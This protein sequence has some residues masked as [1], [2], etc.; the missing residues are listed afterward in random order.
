MNLI[1]VS[2][3]QKNE[4]EI[5][6]TPIYKSYQKLNK[7][8]AIDHKILFTSN[9]N[10][11]SKS[12][13]KSIKIIENNI[14]NNLYK[15]EDTYII[16]VH[17]D[18]YI[19]DIFLKEKLQ[20]AFNNFDIVGVAGSTI[21][22]LNSERVGW[23][24]SSKEYLSGSVEHLVNNKIENSPTYWTYFGIT[25]KRVIVIDGLFIAVKYTS[26][27]DKNYL[28]FDEQFTFDLYDID[29]CLNA[30]KHNL[31]IGTYNIHLTHLSQGEGIND[32]RY[33]KSEHLLR[34]KYNIKYE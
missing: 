18:V 32:E 14:K 28:Y 25:P 9:T 23:H 15:K 4:K 21:I 19:T 7:I 27:N 12:Y 33:I 10:G 5:L 8:N 16:F 3:S 11:L 24:L 26:I 29:F 13:N 6:N 17:D 2:C 30:N 31:K 20:K 1:L 22:D 34:K